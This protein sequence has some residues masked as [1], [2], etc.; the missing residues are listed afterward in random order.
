MLVFGVVLVLAACGRDSGNTD[1]ASTTKPSGLPRLG[2]LIVNDLT[3]TDLRPSGAGQLADAAIA[4]AFRDPKSFTEAAAD[5]LE[6]CKGGL[7]LA[8]ALLVNG[9]PKKAADA[10][11]ARVGI[12]VEVHCPVAESRELNSFRVSTKCERHFGDQHKQDSHSAL[13]TCFDIASRRA[14]GA[15]HGQMRIRGKD[16]DAVLEALAKSKHSGILMEAASEAGE[17]RLLS[18]VDALVRLVGHNDDMV[19]IRAGAALGLLKVQ[20]EDVVVAIARMTRGPRQERH[21]VA[22]NALGDIGGKYA[23][24]YLDNLALGHPAPELRELARETLERL[25]AEAGAGSGDDEELPE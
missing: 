20:R 1:A 25:R 2:E 18:A 23:E 4:A 12:E 24:R 5:D 17:R 13:A 21:L 10:G 6:A 16:D 11:E 15:L 19:S 22:I 9:Q 3:T 14:A 7:D 8:Y